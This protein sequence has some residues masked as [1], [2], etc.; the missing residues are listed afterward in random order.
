M[1]AE[2]EMPAVKGVGWG[3]KT[4]GRYYPDLVASWLAEV[5][6]DQQLRYRAHTLRKAM[7]YLSDDQK[8][9]VRGT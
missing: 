2:W 6:E 3:L 7:L 5:L 8:A 4:M 9:R 1:F